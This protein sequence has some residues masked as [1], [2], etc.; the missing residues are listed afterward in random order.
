MDAVVKKKSI[1]RNII[2]FLAILGPGIIT[3][4]VDNDVG[5]ITTYSVA[6]AEYGYNLLWTLIPAFIVLFVTQEMNARMGIVTGK[7]LADLIR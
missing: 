2:L 4:S 7:G 5:G 1:W 3:G 6:G